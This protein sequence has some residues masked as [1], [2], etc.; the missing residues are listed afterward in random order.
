MQ[1]VM[2]TIRAYWGSPI[3]VNSWFR[4]KNHNEKIGGAIKST[5]M[6]GIAVDIRLID[7]QIEEAFVTLIK[8]LQKKKIIPKLNIIVYDT[9][10]HIDLR[11]IYESK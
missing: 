1:S 2:N 6:Y 10:I 5:H 7:K 9:F 11:N 8:I 4:C 3:Y